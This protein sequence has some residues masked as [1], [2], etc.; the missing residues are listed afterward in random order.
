MFLILM[1]LQWLR[2]LD[3]DKSNTQLQ[4]RTKMSNDNQNYT[5]C[6]GPKEGPLGDWGIDC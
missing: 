3:H 1:E 2:N 5:T 6:G 4:E